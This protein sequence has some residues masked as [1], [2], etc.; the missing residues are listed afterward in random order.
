MKHISKY[1]ELGAVAIMSSIEEITYYKSKSDNQL[2][3]KQ[4]LTGD[5]FDGAKMIWVGEWNKIKGVHLLEYD[6][7]DKIGK[8]IFDVPTAD[9]KSK[10]YNSRSWG[11]EISKEEFEKLLFEYVSNLE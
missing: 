4:I 1:L 3:C 10:W 7:L 11:E 6:K 8:H 5:K 9:F 2:L